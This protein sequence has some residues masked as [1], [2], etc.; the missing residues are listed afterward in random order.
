VTFSIILVTK[1][2]YRIL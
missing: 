1:R 2:N